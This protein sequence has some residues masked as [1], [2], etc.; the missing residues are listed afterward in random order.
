MFLRTGL[1]LF[2]NIFA[3]DVAAFHHGFKSTS[4]QFHASA[5]FC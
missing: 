2:R 3:E 5:F 4:F 1:V